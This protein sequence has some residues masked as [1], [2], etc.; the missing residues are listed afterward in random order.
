VCFP[1]GLVVTGHLTLIHTGDRSAGAID[2]DGML[3]G[4][5]GI[6]VRDGYS[7]YGQLTEALHAWCGAHLRGDLKALYDFEPGN[8]AGRHRGG[9]RQGCG[10][11]VGLR[12]GHTTPSR[13]SRSRD[14]W[15]GGGI[16]LGSLHFM[17]AAAACYVVGDPG[18]GEPG[19]LMQ[20]I[21]AGQTWYPARF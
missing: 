11:P 7:G 13:R 12:T 6:I 19:N 15:N 1:G 4:Y 21:N 16:R 17:S 18:V 2:A 8:W 20:A 3:P 9:Q 5:T 14:P 10:V